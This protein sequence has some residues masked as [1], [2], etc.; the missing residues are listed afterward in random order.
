MITL[1]NTRSVRGQRGTVDDSKLA[2]NCHR[3]LVCIRTSGFVDIQVRVIQIERIRVFFRV[4]VVPDSACG[5]RRII[6]HKRSVLLALFILRL[7]IHRAVVEA[8]T[9]PIGESSPS[10]L[11]GRYGQR[12]SRRTVEFAFQVKSNR[13]PIQDVGT[14]IDFRARS[15][16]ESSCKTAHRE[17]SA[18]RGT[19]LRTGRENDAILAV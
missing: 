12:F 15:N 16:V 2:E 5:E 9:F 3:L 7:H 8:R 17:L 4:Q 19:Q 11:H 10:A 1:R 14:I 6:H 13:V 18:M